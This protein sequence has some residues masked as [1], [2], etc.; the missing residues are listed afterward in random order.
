M[1]AIEAFQLS[2]SFTPGIPV[3]QNLTLVIPRGS[4]FGFLGPNGSGKTTTV[5]LLNGILTPDQGTVAVLGMKFPDDLKKIRSTCGVMTENAALYENMTAQQNL[6]FFAAM[7]GIEFRQ[8]KS[9]SAELLDFFDLT[10]AA[11]QKVKTFSSG[12]KKKLSLAVSLLHSPEI[13]FL[14][15]PTAAL[16]PEA[17][18]EVIELIRHLSA[19]ENKTVFLCTHQLKYAEEICSQYGFINHGKLIGMGT[20]SELEENKKIP[21]T[22]EIRG[23]N[24]P[25]TFGFTYADGLYRK[26]I[27]NDNEASA[28]ITKAINA[29]ATIYEARQKRCSLEDLYFAYC[30]N[31]GGT[32]S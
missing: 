14:D 20:Y 2:K 5:R 4:V 19:E 30:N 3:V 21:V 15:E 29:G 26:T 1:N 32:E 31:N 28:S 6:Y 11:S 9:K 22:L 27:Q 16:D 7:Y 23:A 25:D 18:R 13:L 17:T 8:A 10:N 12:M 24:I